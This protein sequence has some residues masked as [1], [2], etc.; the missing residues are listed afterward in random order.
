[1]MH[2]PCCHILDNCINKYYL[3]HKGKF[4]Y[5]SL[6]RK[7]TELEQ[8]ITIVHS[9]KMYKPL[10]STNFL[11]SMFCASVQTGVGPV[12]NKF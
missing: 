10:P 3:K 12:N 2:A 1:M 8:K 7:K 4:K 11:Q 6:V 5:R 9:V